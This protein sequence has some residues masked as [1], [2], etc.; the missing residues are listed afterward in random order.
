MAKVYLRLQDNENGETASVRMVADPPREEWDEGNFTPAQRLALAA[1][2]GMLKAGKVVSKE[3]PE[4]E[5]EVTEVRSFDCGN[6]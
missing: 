1:Y 2:D 4:T 6:N 5:P 3:D